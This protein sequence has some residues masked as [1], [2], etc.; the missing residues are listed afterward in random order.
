MFINFFQVVLT[1]DCKE[2]S[3]MK[4]WV[5]E[6]LVERGKPKSPDNMLQHCDSNLVEAL[7]AQFTTT[8]PDFKKKYAY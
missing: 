1:D 8:D 2:D 5:R 7:L 6:C 3:F 4:Q